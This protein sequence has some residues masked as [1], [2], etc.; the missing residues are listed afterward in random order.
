MITCDTAS[1]SELADI[2]DW[3][4]EEGWNPGLDDATAFLEADPQGFFVA[5]GPSGDCLASISVVNHSDDFAFLGLYIVRPR[6]RG[7]GIGLGLWHHAMQHAAGRTVGLDGVEAQQ[8]NYKAS[9]F[10]HAGGTTRY[11]GPVRGAV[12]PDMRVATAEDIPRLIAQ[13]AAASGVAKPRYLGAWF[14]PSQT[15]LTLILQ[16]ANGPDAM[17]TVRQCRTGAKIGPLIAEQAKDANRLIAHAATLFDG[18]LTLDVPGP[19]TGL[20]KLCQQLE[21]QPGFKTARM[22][23]GAFSASGQAFF[24]VSSLEL[25]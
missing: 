19:S 18:P 21:L 17:C 12:D 1:P 11:S 8:D 13:E 23:R 4:A 16:K 20:S 5:R 3:A 10:V 6:H 14:T 24:A 2:L 7:K 25:G 22:Y 15:R 9:G